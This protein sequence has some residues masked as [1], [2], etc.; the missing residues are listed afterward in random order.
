M[1]N[2]CSNSIAFYSNDKEKI[3]ELWQNLHDFMANKGDASVYEFLISYAK[4]KKAVNNNV[5]RRDYFTAVDAELGENGEDYY[6]KIE[7]ESAWSPNMQG[8]YDLLSE[9]YDGEV[10]MVYR[11]EEPGCGIFITSDVDE[12]FFTERYYLDYCFQ[13]SCETEY[14]NEHIE[15]MK[16]LKELFPKAEVND[17]DSLQ[18]I[19]EKVETAY[20]EADD[21]FYFNLECFEYD[22]E[23]EL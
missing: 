14:F 22:T 11:S 10:K 4:N 18:E 7:T 20:A 2:Y 16:Y 1:A 13:G 9:N 8:F 5:D 12:L 19:R 3:S 23:K 21:E 17:Y 6:F 15:L